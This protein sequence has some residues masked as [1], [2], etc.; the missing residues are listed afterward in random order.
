MEA[1]LLAEGEFREGGDV[2]HDT[3]R[4]VG[5]RA[6]EEDGVAVDETRYGSHVDLVG[7][8]RAGHEVNL[9]AEVIAGLPEGRVRRV[10]ENPN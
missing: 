7:R 4:E 3:V 2:I 10:R 1:E 6:N 5:C 9:D 8:C